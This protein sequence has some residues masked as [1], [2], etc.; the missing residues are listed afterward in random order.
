MLGVCYDPEQWPENLWAGDAWRIAAQGP[1]YVRIEEFAW[2]A[3]EPD[4][5]RF[6]W[7][8]L[9]R[10]VEA[11]GWAPQDRHG[12][13]DGY[14]VEMAGRPFPRMS[15]RSTTRVKCVVSNRV[16]FAAA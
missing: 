10:A 14:A 12:H 3:I 16:G 6:D 7:S 5:G 13:A 11:V 1:T 2:G 15:C 4:L 9:D 8:W